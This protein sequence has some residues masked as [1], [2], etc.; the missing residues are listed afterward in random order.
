SPGDHGW[1]NSLH[2][3]FPGMLLL[4]SGLVSL[5]RL[6]QDRLAFRPTLLASR[7]WTRSGRTGLV[8]GRFLLRWELGNLDQQSAIA[9]VGMREEGNPVVPGEAGR[10]VRG[11]W[12]AGIPVHVP[13]KGGKLSGNLPRVH[14][15]SLA[16][17]GVG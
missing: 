11:R 4:C 3:G 16:T 1:C 14:S 17:T 12:L 10:F 2:N 7:G 9:C 13:R 5:T 15:I 8:R 6:R